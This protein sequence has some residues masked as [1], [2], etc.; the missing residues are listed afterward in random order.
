MQ[1]RMFSFFSFFI[2]LG[3]ISILSAH[4]DFIIYTPPKC[5][6][7]L[8]AKAMALITGEEPTYLLSELG[9]LENALNLVSEAKERH[10]FVIAH[11]LKDPVL[12]SLTAN[13]YKVIFILRD[14]RDHLVSMAH[15]FLG[16]EWHWMRA[17]QIKDKEALITEL[18]T[19]EQFQWK[20]YEGCIGGRLKS[21]QKLNQ[22]QVWVTRFESLVGPQG[23]GSEKEQTIEIRRLASFIG[24]KISLEEA[25][26]IGAS[27]FG[28]TATFRKGEVGSW[29]EHFTEA[30]VALYKAIYKKKLVKLGYES[31]YKWKK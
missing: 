28:N 11:N 13:G 26:T 20:C 25:K 6:T 14:P 24:K 23:N 16:G 27:L 30:Q 17:S 21:L 5:G 4:D 1:R 2:L 19:G 3:C 9:S 22:E 29:K 15:W 7:H 8:I 18:I 10:S 31:G 12:K